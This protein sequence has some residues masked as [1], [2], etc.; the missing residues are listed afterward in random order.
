MKKP[1]SNTSQKPWPIRWKKPPP[2]DATSDQQ[3]MHR[4]LS[5]TGKVEDGLPPV[6][7]DEQWIRFSERQNGQRKFAQFTRLAIPA[8][9]G[10]VA[11]LLFFIFTPDQ[12]IL[13]EHKLLDTNKHLAE[14]IQLS[15]EGHNVVFTLVP[16]KT[17]EL[18]AGTVAVSGVGD[19]ARVLLQR[20]AR[21][22]MLPGETDSVQLKLLD[23]EILVHVDPEASQTFIV[24]SG[25]L[26]VRVTGTVFGVRV[27]NDHTLVSVWCG[28]VEV[29]GDSSRTIIRKGERVVTRTRDGNIIRRELARTLSSEESSCLGLKEVGKEAQQ[30]V[31]TPTPEPAGILPHPPHHDSMPSPGGQ[32]E[33]VALVPLDDVTGTVIGSSLEEAHEEELSHADGPSRGGAQVELAAIHTRKTATRKI[34]SSHRRQDRSAPATP[35]TAVQQPASKGPPPEKPS[36]SADSKSDSG[37]SGAGSTETGT[38]SLSQREVHYQELSNGSDESAANA[39]FSLGALRYD[40][41][42][43]PHGAIAAWRKYLDRFLRGPLVGDVQASLFQALLAQEKALDAVEHGESALTSIRSGTR[44]RKLRLDV[45]EVFLLTLNDAERAHGHLIQL[46]ETTDKTGERA[47]YLLASA[48][49]AMGDFDAARAMLETY[50]ERYPN[51]HYRKQATQSL[52]SDSTQKNQPV[53]DV[54]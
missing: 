36:E 23:G 47:T 51:G 24:I 2:T 9:A 30:A 42:E 3:L 28:S 48:Y 7:V 13:N 49:A 1:T 39:L 52:D 25:G 31:L 18:T 38:V 11:I 15:A 14:S 22:E 17:F 37:T 46:I 4:F 20:E 44:H 50:L 53:R 45:A 16:G 8:L 34:P 43:D 54:K 26:R 29:T 6:S 32:L 5:A 12:T 21:L 40:K 27:E 19:S 35:K 33:A 10:G 41:L